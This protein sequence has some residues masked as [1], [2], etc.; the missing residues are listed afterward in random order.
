VDWDFI[1]A[2]ACSLGDALARVGNDVR[3]A[4][5]WAADL[6]K[7]RGLVRSEVIRRSRLNQ[8]FAYQI[9]SDARHASRDKLIQLA[10]G[11]D[12]GPKDASRLLEHG[13]VNA[14]LPT[15]RRDVIIAFC[16]E[17]GLD[18]GACE[19]MLWAEGEKTLTQPDV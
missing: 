7:S 4:G 6:I 9:L 12:M 8:T 17:K 16:L 5:V 19:D 2:G 10:F 3:P 18:I 13:G 14:L 1:K 15:C 11:L